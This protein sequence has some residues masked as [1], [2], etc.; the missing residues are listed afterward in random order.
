MATSVAECRVPTTNT[1]VG[2]PDLAFGVYVS[3]TSLLGEDTIWRSL[4]SYGIRPTFEAATGGSTP[5][6]ST[7]ARYLSR[8][9]KIRF[10]AF[11]RSEL[12][13]SS[14]NEFIATT[15]QD[16]RQARACCSGTA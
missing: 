9:I 6:F 5:I 16:L 13:F 14:V 1:N 11:V 3:E 7:P 12:K 2:I 10:L 15:Q 4:T 8:E